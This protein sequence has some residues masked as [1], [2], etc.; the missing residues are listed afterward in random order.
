MMARLYYTD[1]SSPT[2]PSE[3]GSNIGLTDLRDRFR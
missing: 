3:M 2:A 1:P